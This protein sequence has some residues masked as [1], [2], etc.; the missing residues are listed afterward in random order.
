MLRS[1]VRRPDCLSELAEALER[2]IE[3]CGAWDADL[4]VWAM[5]NG[6]PDFETVMAYAR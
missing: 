1:I 3:E 5:D 2:I 4:V 6:F